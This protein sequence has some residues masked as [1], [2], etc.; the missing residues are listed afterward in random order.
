MNI[1]LLTQQRQGHAGWQTQERLCSAARAWACLAHGATTPAE[2]GSWARTQFIPS[3][4]ARAPSTLARTST[5]ARLYCTGL[6]YD[7]GNDIRVGVGEL[8]L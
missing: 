2:Q 8:Y 3:T 6:T 7:F 1:A 4:L 5:H